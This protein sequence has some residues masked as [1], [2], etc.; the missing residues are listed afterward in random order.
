MHIVNMTGS[1]GP[2]VLA[3]KIFRGN[4][5]AGRQKLRYLSV[6][7]PSHPVL[8]N[9]ALTMPLNGIAATETGTLSTNAALFDPI[10]L[11]PTRNSLLINAGTS[12]V[13]G[14]VD[15]LDLLAHNRNHAG[16]TDLGAIEGDA[17]YRLMDGFDRVAAEIPWD[18]AN[19][20]VSRPRRRPRRKTDG[21]CPDAGRTNF[22]RSGLH[23]QR[24]FNS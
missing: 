20:A 12:N 3:N 7:G 10:S 22:T 9:N 4:T 19:S 15:A 24:N 16:A 23:Q 11:V 8:R 14:G 18:L 2:I 6:P 1:S 21:A 13:T 5:A 17:E